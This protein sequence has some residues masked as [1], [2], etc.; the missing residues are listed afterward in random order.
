M[1]AEDKNSLLEYLLRLKIKERIEMLFLPGKWFA[2]QICLSTAM[3]ILAKPPHGWIHKAHLDKA[4]KHPLESNPTG[5]IFLIRKSP[6]CKKIV[7]KR[8]LMPAEICSTGGGVLF[9]TTWCFYGS[10]FFVS[11]PEVKFLW[12][13]LQIQA[14]P[15]SLRRGCPWPPHFPVAL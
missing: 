15:Q 2:S 11:F 5:W 4:L 14:A 10:W 6:I 9:H 13:P 1:D 12:W 7:S 3:P 8:H